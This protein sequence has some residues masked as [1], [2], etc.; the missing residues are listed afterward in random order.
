MS[1]QVLFNQNYSPFFA[2]NSYLVEDHIAIIVLNNGVAT[3]VSDPVNIENA[4]IQVDMSSVN[5]SLTGGTQKTMLID[6]SGLQFNVGVCNGVNQAVL[7]D[8]VDLVNYGYIQPRLLAGNIKVTD[9]NNN[10]NTLA[11]DQKEISLFRVK[12]IWVTGTTANMG[13]VVYY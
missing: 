3:L 13:I 9:V 6:T 10:V 7:S 1:Q 5:Q 12:R 11:F 8:T 2:G 4:T